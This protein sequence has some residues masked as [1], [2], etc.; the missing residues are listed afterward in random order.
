VQ[1]RIRRR[2][3]RSSGLPR[4]RTSGGRGALSRTDESLR[5][6]ELLQR[7]KLTGSKAGA[8]PELESGPPGE[9]MARSASERASG[10]ETSEAPVPEEAGVKEALPADPGAPD[11]PTEEGRPVP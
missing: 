3:T 2:R 4:R 7:V 1:K 8:P 10:G 9:E 5:N 6:E 11:E